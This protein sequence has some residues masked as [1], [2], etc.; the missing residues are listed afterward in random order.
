MGLGSATIGIFFI[1]GTWSYYR[2][3]TTFLKT[4]I[5]TQGT[6][7]EGTV[8][9]GTVIK[10]KNTNPTI[11]FKTKDGRNVI[12][13]Y[14]H[15]RSSSSAFQEV[16]STGS[17]VSIIYQP[18]HPETARINTFYQLW[19]DLLI[20]AFIGTVFTISGITLLIQLAKG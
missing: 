4:A 8:I 18:N 5:T 7:I 14:T 2:D 20:S 9:E 15:N 16:Y 10:A 17:Q 13:N 6:V 3:T 11:Q 12:F 1:I 19:F